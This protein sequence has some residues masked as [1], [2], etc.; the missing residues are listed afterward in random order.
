MIA[1]LVGAHMPIKKGLG[2]A[3]R[4]G[5]VIGCTAIQVFT[6]SPQLWKAKP[7]EDDMVAD[8]RAACEE[9]GINEVVCHDSYLIN[10][11]AAGEE[12]RAKSVQGLTDEMN[13]CAQYGICY[14]NS[15]MGAHVGQGVEEGI[16]LLIEGAKQALADSD[17]SVMLLM[18]TTAATGS[19]L[20]ATFEQLRAVLD[21]LHG[22]KRVAV[23]VDTCHIFAAGY[24]IRTRETFEATFAKFEQVV[25]FDRLKAVHC[26][27]SVG[28][29]GSKKDRHAH[30]GEGE[31]GEEGFR[32]LVNDPRFENIPILLETPI[33]D[34][35]HERDLAK[36]KS[37]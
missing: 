24:D 10:M 6:K 32:L 18:E 21:G 29:L 27:D 4:E 30:I 16:R 15:H 34:H 1:K 22:D 7:I 5:K 13:R 9:T 19:S 3:V 35:G 37:F 36:L 26:N 31:I 33:E 28:A 14:L 8:Y 20:G 11:A 23:C 25:G 2:N 17:P 12:L